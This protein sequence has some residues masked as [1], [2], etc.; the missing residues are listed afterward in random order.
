MQDSDDECDENDAISMCKNTVCTVETYRVN[1]CIKAEAT[2]AVKYNVKKFSDLS[3]QQQLECYRY[4][5]EKQ[6]R[7]QKLLHMDRYQEG[8]QQRSSRLKDAYL[9]RRN[10]K[11]Y[12]EKMKSL[13][14]VPD[15][16]AKDKQQ[17]HGLGH[18]SMESQ[19]IKSRVKSIKSDA[20]IST[21]HTGVVSRR[22]SSRIEARKAP[23]VRSFRTN[24]QKTR[25]ND[26]QQ[27]RKPRRNKHSHS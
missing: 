17:D 6:A 16:N 13:A 23:R 20:K 25:G 18:S 4:M 22:H 27:W 10:R 2:W 19:T 24:T 14:D 5:I 1:A 12:F 7:L 3:K 21:V 26:V 9:E 8:R 11:R 15:C